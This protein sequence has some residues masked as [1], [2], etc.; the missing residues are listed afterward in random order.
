[1]SRD[2]FER[3][4]S[5]ETFERLDHYVTLLNKWNPAINLVS[6]NTLD[7]VWVRHIADSA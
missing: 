2:D 1:M 6:R 4:V 3:D 7:G 5:R